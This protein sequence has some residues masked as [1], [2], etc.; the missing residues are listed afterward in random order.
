MLEKQLREKI[1]EKNV[2]KKNWKKI[3]ITMIYNNIDK[4]D[5]IFALLAHLDSN[6]EKDRE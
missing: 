3:F 1:V 4:C 5:T 2:G 6:R